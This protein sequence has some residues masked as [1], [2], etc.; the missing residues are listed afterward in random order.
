MSDR[1]PMWRRYLR[2]FGADPKA[3]VEDEL[4][5][6]LQERAD[7][8]VA[9]GLTASDARREAERRMGDLPGI[10][11]NLAATDRAHRRRERLRDWARDLGLSFARLRRD[12]GFTLAALA[13][14]ALG[15]GSA[16]GVFTV[17]NAIVLRPLPILILDDWSSSLPPKISTSPLPTRSAR[18][19]HW[20]RRRVSRAGVSPSRDMATRPY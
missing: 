17:V 11:K 13:T 6:H 18:R 15:I 12:P 4:E 10:K 16:V 1:A 3:D 9:K 19:R 20:R 2:L 5:F 14:L 8:L 7:A